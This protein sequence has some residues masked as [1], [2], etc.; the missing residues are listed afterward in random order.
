MLRGI[1]IRHCCAPMFPTD[2]VSEMDDQI[3]WFA[4]DVMARGPGW[5]RPGS[6]SAEGACAED[7]SGGGAS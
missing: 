3:E 7:V 4:A 6:V 1:D 2:G 5:R